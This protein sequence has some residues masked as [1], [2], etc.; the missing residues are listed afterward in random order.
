M[1]KVSYAKKRVWRIV[2]IIPVHSRREAVWT[3]V[4]IIT[5]AQAV[6]SVIPRSRS[7]RILN[8]PLMFSQDNQDSKIVQG[9]GFWHIPLPLSKDS[10]IHI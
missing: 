7:A 8:N 3:F 1:A 4:V 9:K 2:G 10:L 6:P 5:P